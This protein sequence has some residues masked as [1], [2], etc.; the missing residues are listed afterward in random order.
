MT[1]LIVTEVRV[2]LVEGDKEK[3]RAF[4]SVTLNE[5]FVIRDLK[6]I[7]SP[8]GPFVAM[9]SRK[10]G[11]R[12]FKCGEKN[13]YRARFCNECGNKLNPRRAPRDEEGRTKLFADIAHPIT[14]ECR[15]AIES[16]VLE[17]FEEELKLSN[18]PGYVADDFEDEGVSESNDFSEFDEFEKDEQDEPSTWREIKAEEVE[19][20]TPVESRKSRSSSSAPV[21]F[22]V[23]D[24][25][26]GIDLDDDQDSRPKSKKRP[27]S[28]VL[29][30]RP[31]SDFGSETAVNSPESTQN[32]EDDGFAA[33]IL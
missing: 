9:P 18:T 32:T 3:L 14:F 15:E 30:E 24:F 19:S 13:H 28:Q 6:V 10:L 33:G 21:E 23:S 1:D 31:Q 2:N 17:A 16:A 8:N 27:A 5:C 22:E 12:C 7:E 20:L 4:C 29:G 26:A 11:D 25:F